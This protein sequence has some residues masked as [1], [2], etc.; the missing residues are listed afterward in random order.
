MS[1]NLLHTQRVDALYAHLLP[2]LGAAVSISLLLAWVFNGVLAPG[3]LYGWL[4]TVW[5]LAVVQLGVWVAYQRQRRWSTPGPGWVRTAVALTGLAGMAWGLGLGWMAL[6]GSPVQ[7]L[8]AISL[9]LGAI[10]LTIANLAYWQSHAA[11]QV[12][13]LL[14]LGGRPGGRRSRGSRCCRWPRWCCAWRR[15]SSPSA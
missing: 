10:S 4:A 6:A 2:A 9:G 14:C 8:I 3:P 13:V 7:A 11:F 15:S 1:E 5:G 12:P